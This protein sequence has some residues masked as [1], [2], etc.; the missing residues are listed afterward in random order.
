MKK[1]KALL[2]GI[3]LVGVSAVCLAQDDEVPEMYTYASYFEC[4]GGPLA[5]ADDA[6][7]DT[8]EWMDSLVD[9]GVIARWGWL[10]HHTGGNWSRIMYHQAS[11]LW[12]GYSTLVM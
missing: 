8:S 10:A 4:D 3:A 2:T 12:M 6:I 11:V 9:D 7:A 5:A 1:I